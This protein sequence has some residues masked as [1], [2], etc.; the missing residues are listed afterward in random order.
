M[1]VTVLKQ[2]AQ[3]SCID[4]VR[5]KIKQATTSPKIQIGS[6][7]INAVKASTKSDPSN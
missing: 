4:W 2:G 7:K 3:C 5:K 1:H 6:T